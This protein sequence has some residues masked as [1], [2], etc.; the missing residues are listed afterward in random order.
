M[1]KKIA[2]HSNIIK[3]VDL[4]ERK[5]VVVFLCILISS[6]RLLVLMQGFVFYI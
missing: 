6:D 3:D 5:H 2:Q 1:F 4:L